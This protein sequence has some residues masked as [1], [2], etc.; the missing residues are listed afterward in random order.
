MKIRPEQIETFNN[1]AKERLSAKLFS[2]LKTGTPQWCLGKDD[3]EIKLFIREIVD[4]SWGSDIY[5]EANVQKLMLSRIEHNFDLSLTGYAKEQLA[6]ENFNEE[7]RI[8][9][10]LS[11][12]TSG[13]EL[14]RISL[15]TKIGKINNDDWS[16]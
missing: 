12:L 2:F 6:R 14:M 1:K 8:K 7:Y 11:T 16:F 3:G 9:E 15:E 13:G 10:F 4:F 5:K